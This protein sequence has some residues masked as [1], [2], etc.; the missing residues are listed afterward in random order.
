MWLVT[1]GA[2]AIP[3]FIYIFARRQD[4]DASYRRPVDPHGGAE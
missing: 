2:V 1:S 3:A 4:E